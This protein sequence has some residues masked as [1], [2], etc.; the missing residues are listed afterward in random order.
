MSKHESHKPDRYPEHGT[1]ERAK[2]KG[3]STVEKVAGGLAA[4]ATVV[5][6]GYGVSEFNKANEAREAAQ[7]FE[8][9]KKGQEAIADGARAVLTAA[10]EINDFTSQSE[11]GERVIPDYVGKNNDDGVIFMNVRTDP[12]TGVMRQVLGSVNFETGEV[13]AS[14]T[15][16]VPITIKPG[17]KSGSIE[18]T[19]MVS[20]IVPTEYIKAYATDGYVTKSEMKEIA[21]L[22]GAP[23]EVYSWSSATDATGN[24]IDGR[25][26]H[27]SVKR[28]ND[29]WLHH[30]T[31]LEGSGPVSGLSAENLA[32]SLQYD[33]AQAYEK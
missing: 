5:G 28:G 27:Q 29:G 21:K 33:A 10:V 30:T 19:S 8:I 9:L 26:T 32:A 6:L 31:A 2:K 7:Q 24:E 3:P 20:F 4:A 15:N 22:V 13:T 23:T 16:K 14:T 25:V 1:Q 18:G 11:A 17:E 12:D